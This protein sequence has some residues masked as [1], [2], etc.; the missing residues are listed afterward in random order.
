MTISSPLSIFTYAGDGVSMLFVVPFYFINNGDLKVTKIDALGVRTLLTEGIDYSVTGAG[1]LTGGTITTTVAY[2]LGIIIELKRV[3]AILQLD[4]Y[5]ANDVFPAETFEKDLDRLTMIAQQLDLAISAAAAGGAGVTIVNI[6]GAG[7]P[8]FAN[9]VGGLYNFKKLRGLAGVTLTDTGTEIQIAIAG[10]LQ[11]ANNLSDVAAQQTALDN[12][13][14]VAAA[15]NEWVLTKNTA[16]GHA[17]FKP[18]AGGSAPPGGTDKFLRSD[19]TYTN[20]ITAKSLRVEYG[21]TP[22]ELVLKNT[23]GA[24]DNKVWKIWADHAIK[25]LTIS[26]FDDTETNA[27]AGLVFTRLGINLV[28]VQLQA[29]TIVANGVDDGAT[30]LQ[31][32]GGMIFQGASRLMRADT[33]NATAANQFAFQDSTVNSQTQFNIVPNGT[34]VIS[35]IRCHGAASLTNAP[36]ARVRIQS[37]GVKYDS[38]HNGAGTTLPLNL[39]IDGG[40]GLQ[41]T[42]P[43]ARCLIGPGTLPTD[44][45]TSALQI[46]GDISLTGAARR[47]KADFSSAL[48][49]RAIVQTN[50]GPNNNTV[51]T[52]VPLGTATSGIWQ[53]SNS[54]DLTNFSTGDLRVGSL[55]VQIVSAGLGTQP[56]LPIRISPASIIAFEC[57]ILGNVNYRK[58]IA[59]QGY[60]LQTPI[61]GFTITIPNGCSALVLNPAGV[62]ATGTINM[63]TTPI[64]GQRVELLTTQTITALTLSP[65]AGQTISGAVATLTAAAPAAYKYVLSLTKWIK[66]SS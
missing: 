23:A 21:G 29:R 50:S 60:S 37:T 53:V 42:A 62:L 57:D 40:A 6:A 12:L 33:A 59:D 30:A 38:G 47:I 44:D 18:A 61:T 65:N 64:D 51:I 39:T 32:A 54:S 20:I 16:D 3:M 49:V 48:T 13:T 66:A 10:A 8:L 63:P 11:V 19:G 26:A 17:V 9:Q 41:L 1:V 25:T 22:S 7:V 28:S 14:N 34:S 43:G 46:N 15:T 35:E 55:A 52:A 31:V 5:Q 58:A 36:Y 27:G 2:P 45:T 4:D 24:L 56:A